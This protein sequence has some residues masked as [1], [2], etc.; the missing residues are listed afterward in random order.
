MAV[1]AKDLGARDFATL[2]QCLSHLCPLHLGIQHLKLQSAEIQAIFQ[3]PLSSEAAAFLTLQKWVKKKGD[4]AT[5]GAMKEALGLTRE[6]NIA[7]DMGQ[8]SAKLLDILSGSPDDGET[9]LIT[10]FH[11]YSPTCY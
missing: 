6:D 1:P 10:L 5:V 7:T 4:G 9:N 8:N 3:D 2:A 11:C